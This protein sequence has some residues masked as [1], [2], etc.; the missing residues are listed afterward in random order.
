MKLKEVAKIMMIR[1]NRDKIVNQDFDI[2]V[3]VMGNKI[4][5]VFIA[6]EGEEYGMAYAVIRVENEEYR[7][8]VTDKCIQMDWSELANGTVMPSISMRAIAEIE[9]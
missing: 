9:V 8:R 4:G 1:S 5:D 7:N 2:V 6:E 3:G